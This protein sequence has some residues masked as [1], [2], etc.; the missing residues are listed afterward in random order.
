MEYSVN[1]KR[2]IEKLVENI[3]RNNVDMS[4]KNKIK[5]FV[6]ENLRFSIK[7]KI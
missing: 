4:K 3:R 2:L 7:K 1:W 5:I 6:A